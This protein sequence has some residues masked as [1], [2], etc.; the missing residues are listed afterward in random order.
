MTMSMTAA[1]PHPG[2]LPKGE[3]ED[4]SPLAPPGRGAGGE[5]PADG[6]VER[7]AEEPRNVRSKSRLK[8]ELT[9][10][11][12]KFSKEMRH[13]PT[14]AEGR[15]WYFLRNRRLGG[16]KFR[17]QHAVGRFIVDFL[18]IESRLI[19][20]LDGGQHAA[21]PEPDRKR[22]HFLEQRGLQVLRFF[23]D[24]VLK[25]GEKV[26]EAIWWA[27]EADDSRRAATPLPAPHATPHPGPL[28]KGEREDTTPLAPLGRGAGGE[29]PS[30]GPVEGSGEGKCAGRTRP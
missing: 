7:P 17:R 15:M 2:P 24:E 11:L 5:G 8:S 4:I 27:L 26:L 20:E 9:P 28:P 1:S 13:A 23:N 6:T 29:G 10:L 22:A 30:E 16:Y 3:R 25:H 12:K 21:R 18:C 14:D 19:I